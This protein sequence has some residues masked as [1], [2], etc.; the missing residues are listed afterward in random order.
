M[1]SFVSGSLRGVLIPFPSRLF[2]FLIPAQIPQSQPVLL[3]FKS[4]SHFLLFLFDESLSQCTKSHFPASKKGKSQLPFYPLFISGFLLRFLICFSITRNTSK[5][6]DCTV[7]P[8][9]ITS[10]NGVRVLSMWWVILG[11]TYLWLLLYRVLSKLNHVLFFPLCSSSWFR[12]C[13][14]VSTIHAKF[15]CVFFYCCTAHKYRK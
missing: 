2:F 6:M 7:P 15:V 13:L 1:A 14:K 10:V 4:H 12:S 9:A 5:I 3:K 11:H 8:G